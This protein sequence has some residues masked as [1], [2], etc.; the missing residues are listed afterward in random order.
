VKIVRFV[1]ASK[2]TYKVFIRNL[3]VFCLFWNIYS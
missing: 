3:S 1:E 2:Q